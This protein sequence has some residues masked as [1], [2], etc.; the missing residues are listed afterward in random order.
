MGIETH[1][2]CQIKPIWA[3]WLV[4]IYILCV[5][6]QIPPKNQKL[7]QTPW[8]YSTSKLYWPSDRCLSVK[9]VSIF[10]GR[11]CVVSA[12]NFLAVNLGFLD[13]SRY[14]SNQVAPQ[15]SSRGWVDPV[16]DPL[17]LR[18]SDGAGNQTWDLWICNQKFWP[19]DHRGSPNTTNSIINLF[20]I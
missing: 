9:L 11:R 19:P 4:Y 15:L 13:Q 14:F 17:L 6:G 3:V 7:N 16:P 10:A 8:P 20:I 2:N 1:S 18:K 12:T 5:G